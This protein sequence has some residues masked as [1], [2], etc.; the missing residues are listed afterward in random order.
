MQAPATHDVAEEGREPLDQ[1]QHSK[2]RSQVA[3]CLFFSEVRSDVTFILNELSRRMSNPT[4]Q[5]LAKLKREANIQ[6]W[7]I[8]RRGDNIH[9]F[10]LG[11]LQGNSTIIK[12]RCDTAWQA[13]LGKQTR[14]SKRSKQEAG[15]KQSCM[16]QHWERLSQMEL[17]RC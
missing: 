1:V 9:R 5:S 16:L 15:Q 6:V 10:G 4:Q 17:C 7:K 11:R 12:R 8:G 13:L 2:Y 14:A 3:R